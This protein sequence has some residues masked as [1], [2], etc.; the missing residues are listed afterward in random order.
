MELSGR[1]VLLTG[2]SGGIG[3]RTA[4]LLARVGAR[5]TLM[6]RRPEPLAEV[7]AAVEALGGAAVTVPGDVRVRADAER[8]V[9]A[10][11]DR[12][13][14]LDAL[15]NNAGLGFLARI[16]DPAADRAEELLST[17]VLG[18]LCMTRAALPALRSAGRAVIVNV[19]SIAGRIGAP[20][21][22]FYNAS[23]YALI[24]MTE[25][26]RRELLPEGIQVCTVIP[27]AVRGEFL[28]GLG[29][30]HALGKGPAGTV[31]EPEDV[32]RAIR[33]IL[34]R[35]RPE[36]YLPHRN[37]WLGIINVVWPRL[38]DRIVNRLYRYPGGAA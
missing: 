32:A 11:L 38:S 18:P 12:F 22:S 17:N 29:G 2:A 10:A 31:L 35:P 19:A 4:E 7:R 28:E 33:S 9:R 34:L 14:S 15:V 3:R 25:A 21:Y 26:W 37:R 16:D 8:A 36:I 27:A 6:A 13:G 24:G 1:S 30:R 20:Y 23:K 5:V